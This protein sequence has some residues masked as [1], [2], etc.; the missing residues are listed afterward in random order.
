MFG[1]NPGFTIDRTG[2]F[3]GGKIQFKLDVQ[4]GIIRSAAVY[5]VL[6]TGSPRKKWLR[7]R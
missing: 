2:R 1:K 5:M 4:K 3:E 7:Q 6:S